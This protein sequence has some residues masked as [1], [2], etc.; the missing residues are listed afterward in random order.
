MAKRVGKQDE[1]AYTSSNP[2]ILTR[3]DIEW[4]KKSIPGKT[5]NRL[6]LLSSVMPNQKT[7][8]EVYASFQNSSDVFV[9]YKSRYSKIVGAYF[10][11]VFKRPDQNHA[12][13]DRSIY[14]SASVLGVTDQITIGQNGT[15]YQS[16]ELLNTAVFMEGASF[17]FNLDCIDPQKLPQIE[18]IDAGNQDYFRVV[19]P[20]Y[21]AKILTGSPTWTKNDQVDLACV[22]MEFYHGEL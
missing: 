8:Q 2:P 15:A 19:A 20:G 7:P 12:G 6:T 22:Q 5:Y 11:E 10:Q 17:H 9:I 21:S 14:T 3:E 16:D 1:V 18:G 13:N 4:L